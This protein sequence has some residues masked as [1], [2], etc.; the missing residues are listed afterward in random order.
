[1]P[2]VA[3]VVSLVILGQLILSSASADAGDVKFATVTAFPD[4]SGGWHTEM[5]VS[6]KNFPPRFQPP[7]M[8]LTP[9]AHAAP[10]MGT[11]HVKYAQTMFKDG[12]DKLW[13]TALGMDTPHA[14]AAGYAEGYLTQASIFAHYSNNY[15]DWFKDQAPY[16][17]GG[18]NTTAGKEHR[19]GPTD[20]FNW[21]LDNYKWTKEKAVFVSS[22]SSSSS[23]SNDDDR[24]YWTWVRATLDQLEGMVAGYNKAA[25]AAERLDL[26]DFLLLNADGDVES[27]QDALQLSA[28]AR[29][30]G[31]RE[32]RCSAMFKL[33]PGNA[34]IL[35][36]HT[37]WDHFDMM[38]RTLKTYSW[39]TD[40]SSSSLLAEEPKLD[41]MNKSGVTTVSMSSSPGFL[42]SVDDFYLT[43]AGLGI[44]ETTNG[45]FNP[46]LW[47]FIT[48]KSV[49][50]WIRANVANLMA[51]TAPQWTT[52][53]ARENSGT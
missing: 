36:G 6:N 17:E 39:A 35:F 7:L 8:P 24:A 52:V 47:D 3:A 41:C 21:L 14:F 46:K 29:A 50:S 19:F 1:M 43:N 44:I 4:G 22:G 49:L 23:S 51:T 5:E 31:P 38:R 42:S 12:W 28:K 9:F 18:G 26:K 10:K 48:P 34:D 13:V 32:E 27:L 11:A 20:V 25:P 37:T 40:P 53:F 2:A 15:A 16:G 33:A 30:A 45:N